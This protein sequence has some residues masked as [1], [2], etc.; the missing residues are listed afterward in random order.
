MMSC[1]VDNVLN[2]AQQ[3]TMLMSLI[4]TSKCLFHVKAP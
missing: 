3:K 4:N 2:V 1:L